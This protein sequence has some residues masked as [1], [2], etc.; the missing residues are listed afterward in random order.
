MKTQLSP[1]QRGL[2]HTHTQRT[3][4]GRNA[5]RLSEQQQLQQQQQ[6][7]G[8]L[9]AIFIQSCDECPVSQSPEPSVIESSVAYPNCASV[10]NPPPTLSAPPLHPT[11]SSAPRSPGSRDLRDT[12]QQ[13]AN[14]W[15]AVAL[16]T[17]E[18][19]R[20]NS[21]GELEIDGRAPTRAPSNQNTP[22][23]VCVCVCV[24]VSVTITR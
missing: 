7:Q 14:R 19:R 16:L 18:G 3:N 5:F 2:R 22:V 23:D 13:V 6:Q 10:V 1:I 21:A 8:K 4:P 12:R 24:G 15:P 17:S 20:G 11:P 9:G